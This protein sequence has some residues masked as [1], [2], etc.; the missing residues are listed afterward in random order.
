MYDN[1]WQLTAR[2]PSF[3]S[4][5]G[6]MWSQFDTSSV[7][8]VAYKGATLTR[9]NLNQAG[10][11]DYSS[12]DATKT[13]VLASAVRADGTSFPWALR[14]R[15]LT[16][17]GEIPFT[18]TDETDRQIIFSDLLFD[19][20]APSTPERHRALVRLEDIN[21]TNDPAQLRAAADWLASQGVPFGFGVSPRYLDP[22]GHY[23]NGV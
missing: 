21:P 7:T 2:D 9:S 15:N 23:N 11:M 12:L 10:I 16:Y 14:S 19:A 4:D 17:V 18:Y 20:L 1:I 22:T 8:S 6:W 13:T 5:Y 3:S